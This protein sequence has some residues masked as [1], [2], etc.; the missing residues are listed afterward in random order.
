M[1][2]TAICLL[3]L[4][5]GC[6]GKDSD[7]GNNNQNNN[8]PPACGNAAT[9]PGEACDQTDLNGFDCLTVAAGFVGGELT[10]LSDCSGYDVSA[11]TAGNTI[12]VV[13]GG[14]NPSCEQDDVQAAVDSA[15]DGDTVEVGEGTCTYTT[16]GT[17]LASVETDKNIV[18]RG[19]GTQRTVIVDATGDGHN[20][21]PFALSGSDKPVRLTGFTFQGTSSGKGVISIGGYQNWRVDHNEFLDLGGRG[22]M[23]YG[24]S[25][26]VADHNVFLNVTNG[27]TPTGSGD[28]SWQVPISLGTRNFV[29]IED[30]D[31]DYTENVSDGGLDAYGGARYVYRNNYVRNTGIG[32]HGMDSGNY[33]GVHS[34]EI[35]GNEF[36]F[37]GLPGLDHIWTVMHFRSGTGVVYNNTATGE[38]DWFINVANY[39][40][41]CINGTTS[42]SD[43]GRCDGTNPLD[44]NLDSSGYPCSDQIGR[45]SDADGDGIQDSE[46]LYEWNNTLKQGDGN[47]QVHPH[48][49]DPPNEYDHI[50]ENRD[51]FNDTPRPGYTPYV[52]PHPLVQIAP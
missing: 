2:W 52:Y 13:D 36:V 50:Q 24:D 41:C 30:N 33:R 15:Q 32:H 6:G 8:I 29:F 39:R 19:A 22:I 21:V 42:C 34:Y 7:N 23:V 10:C 37:D 3:I 46:P 51:Y 5:C 40:S 14:D 25:Y 35:Y 20:E 48:G 28:S 12:Q 47:I 45:S 16:P 31:F 17:H 44:G 43:W 9:E 26:G 38:F 27:V 1:K 11:C 18:L 49:C 4:A